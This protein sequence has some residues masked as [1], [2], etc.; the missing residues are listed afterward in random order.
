[1]T[2]IGALIG[3]AFQ[4]DESADDL[5]LRLSQ[6]RDD[7]KAA[8]FGRMLAA[9]DQSWRKWVT[10]ELEMGTHPDTIVDVMVNFAGNNAASMLLYAPEAWKKG[11]EFMARRFAKDFEHCIIVT[12]DEAAKAKAE[13]RRTI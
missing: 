13:G 3:G 11:P 2:K 10:A 1:M 5:I 8:T 12:L 9:I 7:P 6:V 4:D